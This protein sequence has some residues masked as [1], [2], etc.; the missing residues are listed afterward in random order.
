MNRIIL[1]LIAVAFVGCEE[2]P[3]THRKFQSSFESVSDFD[4]FYI[5]PQGYLGTSYHNIQDTM[6]HSGTYA[7][8]AWV[9]DT[10]PPS[11][12]FQNNNHRGYPTIQFDNTP[13][14]VFRTPCY[15][16]LW[17]YLDMALYPHT[18]END[19]FS[20]ATFTSD[21][22]D[23]WSRTVLINL[24]Y[25]DS[26]IRL[27]HVPNQGQQQHIYQTTTVKF[28]QREWVEIKAYLDFDPVNGYA[29]V[30]QNGVLV[31]QA[32]VDGCNGNLAQAHFGLYC[33][34]RTSSGFIV[35]D[36]LLIEEVHH[37]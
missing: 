28:P 2:S 24:A 18:P 3:H 8:I 29:K 35:N 32:E 23:N 1:V 16:T 21:E 12:I 26:C 25:E 19:W 22:S 7:H 33:S 36:D 5:S 6:V 27:V 20:F 37:E 30:W 11:T 9:T 14:G 34:P 31:S 13:E 10:N 4:G 17:V 15:V